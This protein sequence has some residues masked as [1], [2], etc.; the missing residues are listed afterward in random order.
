[1]NGSRR[2]NP[3]D[4]ETVDERVRAFHD[5]HPAGTILTDIVEMGDKRVIIRATVSR[6]GSRVDAT[7]H[8]MEVIG[9]SAV[10]QTSALENCE[11]SAV[12]RAL[13]NLGV[14]SRGGPSR[15]EM[16][17]HHAAQDDGHIPTTPA[18]LV[19]LIGKARDTKDLDAVRTL[20]V[21]SHLPGA[22][23]LDLRARWDERLREVTGG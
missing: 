22:V 12:G 8:A 14:S 3:A 6:D 10:N 9:S 23:K 5:R 15:E 21:T 17:N 20:I 16:E 4:Y 13:R 1:M 2:F 7:G 11:T 19:D 18:E